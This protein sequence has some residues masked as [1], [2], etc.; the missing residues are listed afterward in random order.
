MLRYLEWWNSLDPFNETEI[1][2]LEE[3]R[4]TEP[5]KRE[6]FEKVENVLFSKMPLF[7][8]FQDY[9]ISFDYCATNIIK[10]LFEQY[11]GDDTLVIYSNCEHD[12][13]K[14]CVASCKNS[15]EIDHQ[16]EIRALDYSKILSAIKKYK[17]VFV[18]I[19]GTQISSGEI[20]PQLF[21]IKLKELLTLNNIKHTIVLDDVHG[22]FIIPRDYSLFDHIINTAHALIEGFDLGMV[23]SKN[24]PFAIQATN[25]GIEYIQKLCIILNRLPKL[26][27]F[28]HCMENYFTSYLARDYISLPNRTAP[29]I[30]ALKTTGLT[31]SAQSHELLRNYTIS[32]E[33]IDQHEAYIRFR[34]AQIMRNPEAFY[35]G[36]NYLQR[37][38]QEMGIN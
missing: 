27:L 5:T 4:S 37:L 7:N 6:G 31:F 25:W 11:V 26:N 19:I 3:K 18:Y 32:L 33:G 35:K 38:M 13:V 1:Q 23:I 20:T 36:L 16:R 2:F 8:N 29:H 28:H 10:K 22:M 9:H 30:F 17:K 12:N 34:A 21:F 24:K 14:T 15:L